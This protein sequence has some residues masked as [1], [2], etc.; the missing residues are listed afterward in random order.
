[1]YK[2]QIICVVEEPKD[3]AAI[4]RTREFRGKYH[5]LGGAISC[6]LYT[7]D[8][9]DEDDAGEA[10]VVEAEPYAPKPGEV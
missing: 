1:M 6:L 2:R 8:A 4:E 5:V 10:E 7:S 9:A 3:V